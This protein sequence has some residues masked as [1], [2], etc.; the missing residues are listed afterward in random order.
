[1]L[2][3][4]AYGVVAALAGPMAFVACLVIPSRR[5]AVLATAALLANLAGVWRSGS[6]TAALCGAIALCALVAAMSRASAELRRR[7]MPLALAGAVVTVALVVAGSAIGPVRRLLELPDSPVAAAKN[8]AR[9]MD[10][11]ATKV[12]AREYDQAST[13]K[14]LADISGDAET[15]GAGGVRGAEQAAMALDRLYATWSKAPGNK[16]DK[17]VSDALDRIFGS[18]EDPAKFDAKKFAADMKAVQAALPK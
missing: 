15:I 5:G 13:R 9:T 6:R 8:V 10:Q 11:Q 7:L 16:A 1:M 14:L 17:A 4:N 3:A 18:L 2:D 12:A